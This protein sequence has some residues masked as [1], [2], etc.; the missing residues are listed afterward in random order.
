M[1]RQIR[2]QSKVTF[3]IPDDI[4]IELLEWGKVRGISVRQ[5]IRQVFK[6]IY[7]SRGYSANY[8]RPEETHHEVH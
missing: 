1:S 5:Q 8:S 4:V 3:D 2:K 6:D 7:R